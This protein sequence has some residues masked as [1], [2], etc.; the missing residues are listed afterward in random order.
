MC[1]CNEGIVV[2]V[3]L[4]P[5]SWRNSAG[6]AGAGGAEPAARASG[7]LIGARI[8]RVLS[9]AKSKVASFHCDG[10]DIFT[11]GSVIGER[12][13]SLFELK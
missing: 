8:S 4:L 12:V 11:V 2:E 6:T 9:L 10:L 1:V 13:D 3:N 5:S 7:F